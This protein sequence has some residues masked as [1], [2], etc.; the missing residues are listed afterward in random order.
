M[1]WLGEDEFG[2]GSRLRVAVTTVLE[3]LSLY[4]PES[5]NSLL[6]HWHAMRRVLRML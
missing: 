6:T 1:F 3:G 4:T 5:L 2:G